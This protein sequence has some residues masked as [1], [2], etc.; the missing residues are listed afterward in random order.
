MG[1]QVHQGAHTGGKIQWGYVYGTAYVEVKR[2]LIQRKAEAGFY[3]LNRTDLTFEAL[4][5]VWLHSC[6]TV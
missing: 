2:V 4:A 3:N 5:E 6:G 1:R